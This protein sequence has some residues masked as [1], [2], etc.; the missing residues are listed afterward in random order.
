MTNIRMVL[1]GTA[2]W[3]QVSQVEMSIAQVMG[4]NLPCVFRYMVSSQ[5]LT[6]EQ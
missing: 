6:S 5:Q 3:G 1:A 4:T 2:T